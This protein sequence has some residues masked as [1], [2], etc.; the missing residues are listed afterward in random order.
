M[1]LD[2]NTSPYYDDFNAA[3]D[4]HRILFKPGVAVQARELTQVQSLLQNQINEGMAFTLQEGAIV[5]GCAE[6][7]TDIEWVKILDTDASSAA[8]DNSTLASF[9]GDTVTGG[10]SGLI[11]Q[12]VEVATGTEAASPALKK[13]YIQYTNFGSQTTYTHFNAS[14]TLTVTSTDSSRNGKTFVVGSG[15]STTSVK[16]NYFGQTK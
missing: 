13:I 2:L 11:G 6:T 3:K 15:T 8:V 4:F 16:A 9:V 10:T 12:I 14:E 7:W 5:T 1:A